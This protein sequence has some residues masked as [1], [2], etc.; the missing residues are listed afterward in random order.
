MNNNRYKNEIVQININ[1]NYSTQVTGEHPIPIASV[2]F[3]I[4]IQ[5]LQMGEEYLMQGNNLV[6]EVEVKKVDNT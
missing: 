6:G 2:N 4:K 3:V 1:W 5:D